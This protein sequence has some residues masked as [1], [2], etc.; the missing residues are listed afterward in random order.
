M[1]VDVRIHASSGALIGWPQ[2]GQWM[3]LSLVMIGLLMI[4]L[5]LFVWV[6]RV[7]EGDLNLRGFVDG[8][9]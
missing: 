7:L 4:V 6:L 5:P 1:S 3:T 2:A 9:I 8:H